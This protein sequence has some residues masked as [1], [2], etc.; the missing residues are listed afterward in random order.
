MPVF[1][2]L[3]LI[4]PKVINALDFSSKIEPQSH[5]VY[6]NECI[7]AISRAM[8]ISGMPDNVCVYKDEIWSSSFNQEYSVV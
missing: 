4:I 6:L 5:Y 8:K 2:S 7:Y 3:L 1:K